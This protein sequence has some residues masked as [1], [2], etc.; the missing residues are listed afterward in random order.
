MQ[1]KG[2]DAAAIDTELRRLFTTGDLRLPSGQAYAYTLSEGQRLGPKLTN[3][4]P[5]FMLYQPF[6]K[7]AAMGGDPATPQF[8]F[9]GPYENHPLST[10]VVWMTEFV[11]PKDVTLSGK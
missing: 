11:S 10:I 4:R 2:M 3:Y 1:A 6:A 7:N 5:H 9:V 8:P